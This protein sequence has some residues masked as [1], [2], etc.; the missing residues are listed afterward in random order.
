LLSDAG[1]V[2]EGIQRFGFRYV[3]MD[4]AGYQTGSMND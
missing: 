4:L 2:I 3:T 1:T